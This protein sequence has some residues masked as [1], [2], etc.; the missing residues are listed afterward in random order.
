MARTQLLYVVLAAILVLLAALTT[1]AGTAVIWFRICPFV[2]TT[3]A[4]LLFARQRDLAI[5]RRCH[6]G[7]AG[8]IQYAPRSRALVVARRRCAWPREGRRLIIGPAPPRTLLEV[9]AARSVMRRLAERERGRQARMLLRTFQNRGRC[10]RDP[11]GRHDSHVA[12]RN[13][14]GIAA[15]VEIFCMFS[16]LPD[17][18][19][20][21]AK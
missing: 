10:Q 14:P 9:W 17:G 4:A 6:A 8:A 20:P 7:R 2:L 12:Q 1:G 19:A 11:R 16:E 15:V 5:H 21:D 18:F 13:D 3:A